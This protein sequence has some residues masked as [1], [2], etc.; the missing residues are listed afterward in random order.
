MP[1]ATSRVHIL[2]PMGKSVTSHRTIWWPLMTSSATSC[3]T[4]C[5]LPCDY[6]HIMWDH[7]PPPI[8]PSS[9]SCM[10]VCHL[11]WYHLM[12]LMSIWH[13][14][15]YSLPPQMGLLSPLRPSALSSHGTLSHIPRD[16]LLLPMWPSA[17]SH[18]LGCHFSRGH[19]SPAIAPFVTSHECICLLC[20][21]HLKVLM[22]SSAIS[23][24]LTCHFPWSYL[25]PPIGPFVTSHGPIYPLPL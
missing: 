14:S 8:A 5:H 16:H 17:Y 24:G 6:H 25:L 19:L 1:S 13:F 12:P 10:T 21:N 4:I 11:P 20:S 7:P 23:N 18:R 9:I 15:G 22:G 3:G 2:P